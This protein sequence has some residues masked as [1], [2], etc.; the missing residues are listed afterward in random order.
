MEERVPPGVLVI[1]CT[2]CGLR[3]RN[4]DR[5]GP[6]P[7]LCDVCYQHRGKQT[8]NRLARAETHE[9]MLRE[10]LDACRTSEARANQRLEKAKEQVAAALGSRG[11][12]A[13]RIVRAAEG[14]PT[15]R[16]ELQIGR[17]PQV[18]AFARQHEERRGRWDFEE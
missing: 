15:G 18:I 7:T 5:D 4:R 2:C 9:Q 12:L 14:D 11:L 17:D 3:Q 1:A 16:A 10:R 13:S 8:E 6:V